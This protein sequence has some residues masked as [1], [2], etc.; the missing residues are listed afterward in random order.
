M[1]SII[2]KAL[3]TSRC[4]AEFG[5][6]F[7][8]TKVGECSELFLKLW[9][10]WGNNAVIFPKNILQPVTMPYNRASWHMIKSEMGVKAFAEKHNIAESYEYQ[11]RGSEVRFKCEDTALLYRLQ[12]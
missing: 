9:D 1:N 3:N 4:V 6:E 12:L 7:G 11:V 5:K 8:E 2:E 10:K